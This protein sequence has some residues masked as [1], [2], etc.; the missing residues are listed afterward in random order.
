MQ[1]LQNVSLA[2]YSTM[3]LGG[4]AK[5]FVSVSSED[6][7]MQALDFA[8]QNNLKTHILG[9]GSN[10]IFS[11]KG[12]NGLVIQNA[13]MGIKTLQTKDSLTLTVGAGEKWDDIVALGV[14]NGYFDIAALSLIPGTV[15]AAPV[16]NIGAYGQQ[17][18]DAI[19]SVRAYD[20]VGLGFIE[21]PQAD[22]GFAYRKSRFNTVDKSRFIIT[23]IK[24]Q[25]SRKTESAPFYADISNYFE[26]H[27]IE[28]SSISPAQ[29]RQAVSTVRVIKLPDPSTVANC[30]S[31]FKNPVVSAEEHAALLEKFPDLKSHQTDDGS[32]KL[33]AGQL[34]ELCD[35]KNYH[36]PKT[37]M[38]TWKN[39][40]LVLV[41]ESAK[42]TNDL[43]LFKQFIVNAVEGAFN[44]TLIQEPEFI[45]N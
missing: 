20:T 25:L 34:I 39:Q 38:A 11:D 17:V 2:D 44:I 6:E 4:L 1:I 31:F 30:G 10:T 8:A 27:S 33:Y 15:G 22:C 43:L 29:L 3:R 28:Q 26:T 12:F 42:S 18:S 16:Q 32:L 40:A 45:E 35:L 37:G 19:I 9:G 5:N 13:V 7:L 24:L 14:D 36:D 41:N 21:I 23:S